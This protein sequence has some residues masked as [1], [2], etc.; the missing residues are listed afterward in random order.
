MVVFALMGALWL[1]ASFQSRLLRLSPEDS[2]AF[3]LI[4]I[5]INAVN[6]C[7]PVTLLAFGETGL[8]RAAIFAGGHSIVSNTLGAYIAARGRASGIETAVRQALR[9]PMIY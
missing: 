5:I 9:I 6:Y 7:F 8:E 1:L 3:V 2:S 4:S